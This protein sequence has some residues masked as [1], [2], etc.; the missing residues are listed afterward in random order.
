MSTK[1][2]TCPVC[3]APINLPLNPE[4][5]EIINCSDCQSQLVVDSI[6]DG[7]VTL[8]QAPQVEEDWGE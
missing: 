7:V 1:N 3:D 8:S 2:L 6:I 4:E 5:S